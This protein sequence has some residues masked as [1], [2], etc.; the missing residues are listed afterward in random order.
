[1]DA[2]WMAAGE[3]AA[4]VRARKVSAAEL[5]EHFRKRV[6]QHNPKV[7]AVVVFDWERAREQAVAADA[8]L[9]KGTATGPLHGVPM[10]VKECFDV[11]GLPTTAG[12]VALKANA[13]LRHADAVKKLV[14]AGAV[15]FGKTNTPL[16]AGDFQTYNEVY[17]T[18]NNPWDPTRGPGGSSGGSAA[19]LASG[20]TPLELG[21]D[22]GGSIRNP[23]HF[24]GVYGHKPS[25]GIVPLRGHV[26]GPPNSRYLPDIAVAGPL[27]R[28]ADDLDLALSV[29]A[30]PGEWEAVA[31]RIDLPAPRRSSLKDYR[32]ALC[33]DDAFCPVDT[34]IADAITRAGGALAKAGATV[35]QSKP[36]IDFGDSF[37]LFY[38]MLAAT[39]APSYDEPL[40]EQMALGAKAA[41]DQ[42]AMST[43]FLQGATMRHIDYIRAAAARQEERARWSDFF[44]GYDVFL[45]PIVMTTAF[46][47]DHS[48]DLQGRR[49]TVNGV[50]RGYLEAIGWA[51]LIGN[52][53][54]P[55]T[56]VPVGRTKAGLPIGMQIVGPYLEDRTCIDVARHLASAIGGFT[57]PPGYA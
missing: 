50:Q 16:F 5:L 6:D 13:A 20:M 3:L 26:P 37:R 46:A 35:R 47:H 17:G 41:T 33:P 54:L 39:L 14:E 23:A 19:A 18:T 10:T 42:R 52:V 31:W 49:L 53:R 1:M 28:N 25:F 2:T 44:T 22:I 56:V 36:A 34:E 12:A 55:S 30:G 8:A 32:I 4:A 11:E 27:A 48:P 29:V 40:L 21:S 7:N 9:A 15:I 43:I 38:R 24:C 57:S 45:C 51:G